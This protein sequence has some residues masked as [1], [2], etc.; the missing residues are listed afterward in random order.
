ML[1]SESASHSVVSD[2]LWPPR[3]VA[4]Q[5]AL[6]VGISREEYW[7][8]LPC[9]PPEESSRPRNWTQVSHI[10]SRFFTIC[11][12]RGAHVPCWHPLKCTNMPK[13][14]HGHP[15]IM[16]S[17]VLFSCLV[18]DHL[19]N[20]FS[21]CTPWSWIWNSLRVFCLLAYGLP[22]IGNVR[23]RFKADSQY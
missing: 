10:A 12:T 6:S 8:G 21:C 11:A 18:S 13:R 9:P 7:S 23:L 3:T 5:P 22:G 14:L 4:C 15:S 17:S 20:A 2:F 19:V 16:D 1:K